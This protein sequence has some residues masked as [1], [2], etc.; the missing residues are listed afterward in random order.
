VLEPEDWML[1][2][3]RLHDSPAGAVT[4]RVIVPV[5]PFCGATVI[6]AV[7]DEPLLKLSDET[8]AI[9]IIS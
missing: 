2:G 1:V 6:M 9:I 3:L 5:K 7:A 4:E 8:F